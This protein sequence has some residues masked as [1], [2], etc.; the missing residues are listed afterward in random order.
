MC[1]RGTNNSLN[2]RERSKKQEK[3]YRNK[4]RQYQ[5]S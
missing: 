2:G 3:L 1:N 5:N 4:E